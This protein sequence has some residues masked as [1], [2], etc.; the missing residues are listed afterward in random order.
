VSKDIIHKTDAGGIALDIEN[1]EEV[2]DAFEAIMHSCKRY[3]PDALIEGIEI[4]EMVKP[5]AETIVGARQDNSFGPIV[6]FGLGGIYVEVMKDVVFRSFPLGGS[7]VMKMVAGIRSY[8][9]L[10]GARGEAKKDI[11]KIAD[12]IMRVGAILYK[13]REISDIEIN[14]LIAYPE[15]EGVKALDAR[16][17]L[18]NPD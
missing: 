1:K 4:A 16:I 13:H 6:M 7:E 3:N 14:P 10:L 5:G 11:P 12:A 17:L 2:I 18:T 8:P 9:L 15:G